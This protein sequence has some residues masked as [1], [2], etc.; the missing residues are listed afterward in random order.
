MWH[1]AG[2]THMDT[3][4]VLAKCRYEIGLAKVNPAEKQAMLS[5]CMKSKGFRYTY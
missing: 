5:D 3:Q 2:V 1:K 4:S